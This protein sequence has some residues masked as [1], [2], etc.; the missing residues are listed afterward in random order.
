[1]GQFAGVDSII[2]LNSEGD[3]ATM[4]RLMII[5]GGVVGAMIAYELSKL[6]GLSLTLIERD[7]PAS[8]AT[9]AALG[10]LMGAIS[11]KKQ[12]RAWQWR[13]TSLRYYD[14]LLPELENLTG[15]IVAYNRQGLVLLRFEE[16]DR[17]RWET[18]QQVRHRQGW[19]LQL[20]ERNRLAQA[21]PHLDVSRIVGAVYSEGDRQIHPTQLTQTLVK[22][23]RGNGVDCRMG[24]KVKALHTEG[25]R[26][27]QVQTDAGEISCDHVIIAAGLGSLGLTEPLGAGIKLRPVLGQGIQIHCDR[28]LGNANFQPVVTGDD[29]HI[30]PIG[31]GDYWVGA[32]F[33]FPDAQNQVI[34][35]AE[36]LE[37][38]YQRAI[39]FC[40]PLAQ[41]TITHHWSGLRPRPE[42]ESA[43]IV[44]PLLGYANILLATGHYRNGV[45]LAP[46]TALAVRDWVRE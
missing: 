20:W 3:F 33:E 1:L 14:T 38:V 44:R 24:L 7:S 46:A 42:G 40:P 23:A 29:V 43:P 39:A 10:V 34:P 27:T 12:G 41:G 31:K 21:C 8:G 35:Q 36:A 6:A 16:S 9:G 4:T 13:Q 17:P 2:G 45:L 32:T 5:G 37:Q 15:D 19:R 26:C 28:P 25:D 30:V 22:A 11:Q 18:L